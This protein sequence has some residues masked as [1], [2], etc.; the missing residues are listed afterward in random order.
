MIEPTYTTRS[1]IPGTRF[2]P[3]LPVSSSWTRSGRITILQSPCASVSPCPA[4]SS[5]SPSRTFPRPPASEP[6]HVASI[7]FETPRKSATYAVLGSS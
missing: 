1:T 7:R 2:S 4:A 6:S 3:V 5:N